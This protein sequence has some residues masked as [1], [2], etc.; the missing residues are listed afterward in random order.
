MLMKIIIKNHAIRVKEGT[1]DPQSHCSAETRCRIQT[2]S[3][4][5][6]TLPL[7]SQSFE[8]IYISFYE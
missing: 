4:A 8:V 2:L 7:I 6:M 1:G 5:M 3:Q